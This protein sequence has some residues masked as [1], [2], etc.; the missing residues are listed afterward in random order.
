MPL[1]D[2]Q[3]DILR[4]ALAMRGLSHAD[5]PC[6]AALFD[7]FIERELGLD[8]AAY[9]D[10]P[11][12]DPQVGLPCGLERHPVPYTWGTVNIWTLQTERGTLVVDSGCSEEQLRSVTASPPALMLLTHAHADHA[13]GLGA[14]NGVI[15]GDGFPPPPPQWGEWKIRSLSLVGHTPTAQGF[16]LTH[17]AWTLF[18]TGDALF[19][20]SVGKVSCARREAVPMLR[21]IL[22]SLSEETIL[23]PGHGPATVR[24]LE[25]RHN[26]F[27]AGKKE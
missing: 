27:L 25:E 18:F 16:V 7:R 3:S 10:L 9:H 14:V 12:Y 21:R 1:E 22:S 11:T 19:A 17:G 24:W 8:P 23:C 4:K 15:C 6:D 5:V 26:P 13:G 2:N 20:G